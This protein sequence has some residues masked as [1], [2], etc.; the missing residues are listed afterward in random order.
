MNEKYTLITGASKGIGKEM[1]IQCA[2]KNLNIILVARSE[3]KL[4][5]LKEDLSKKYGVNVY[6][7]VLD[8][9]KKNMADELYKWCLKKGISV[10]ML[11]NNAGF[12][13][14]GKFPELE[15][16][17]QLN[18]ID[19]NIKA[20]LSLTYRFLEM[21]KSHD[22][23][24]ILNV[25]SL[26][27]L[28]PLPYGAVYSASKAFISSFSDS[29]RYELRNSNISVS[30]VYPG[31][32]SSNFFDETKIHIS[33]RDFSMTPEQ[34]AEESI[35]KLLKNKSRI[36]PKHTK[37]IKFV[38]KIPKFITTFFGSKWVEKKLN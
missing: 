37:L 29:L 31:D 18:L 9:T 19:L 21:I 33:K 1:A 26:V 20:V 25:S 3:E 28:F 2:S 7:Y 12:G 14:F 17:K 34:V 10:N 6:Y 4:K 22:Q 15:L 27:G 35:K 24:Y 11:I 5:K 32:T 8:L 36:F 30:C 16:E 13:M 23:G 38:D